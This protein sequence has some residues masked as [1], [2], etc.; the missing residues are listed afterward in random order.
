MLA[1]S[2]LGLYTLARPCVKACVSAVGFHAPRSVCHAFLRKGSA[3]HLGLQSR[4]AVVQT[5]RGSSYL[6]E[7]WRFLVNEASLH[8][9]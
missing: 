6:A 4:G 3:V 9:T 7:Y 1:S 2:H 8:S 5:V